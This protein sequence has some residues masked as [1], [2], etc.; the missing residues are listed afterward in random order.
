[1]FTVLAFLNRF[2]PSP[3]DEGLRVAIFAR[4]GGGKSNLAALF[5]EQ[6]LE[7]GLQILVIEPLREY[8]T[9]KK[10]MMLCGLL[11][12]ATFC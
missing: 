7:Q 5:A 11:R 8:N 6:A 12:E 9:L 4:S 3:C 1:M 10:R 2:Y